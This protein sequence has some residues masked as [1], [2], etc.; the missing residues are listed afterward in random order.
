M[1]TPSSDRISAGNEVIYAYHPVRQ[2][3]ITGILI[4]IVNNTVNKFLA[5]WLI[6]EQVARE[7][8]FPPLECKWSFICFL[9]KL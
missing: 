7:R 9:I 2:L 6:S 1:E 4:P 3:R 5:Y 8:H